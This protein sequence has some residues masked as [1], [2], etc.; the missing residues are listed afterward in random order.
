MKSKLLYLGLI[1]TLLLVFGATWLF[2]EGE[3]VMYHAC[4]NNDSGTIKMVE[5][6]E[7]CKTNEIKVSWNS[8]GP[9]GPQ[10]PTGPE[11]PQGPIGPEGLQGPI[12][13][14]GPQGP[15][16]P[17]IALGALSTTG[18]LGGSGGSPFGPLDC[19][20]GSIAVGFKGRAGDDID[21]TELWCRELVGLSLFGP[22][23]GLETSGGAI[24]SS[25]GGEDYGTALLCPPQSALTGIRVRAGDVGFGFIVD[26]MGSRCTTFDGTTLDVGFVGLQG[27]SGVIVNLDCPTGAVVT[28]FQGRQGLLLDQIALRCRQTIP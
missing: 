6:D 14:E 13:P 12:G 21:R 26:Q 3:A 28:G 4:A 2:A 22:V 5:A 27:S 25:T 19:L 8:I 16:G 24:G 18:T 20:S 23:L 11:G 15:P 17:S 10:G 7:P 9:E 1:L